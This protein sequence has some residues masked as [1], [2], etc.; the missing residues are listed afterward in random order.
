MSTQKSYRGLEINDNYGLEIIDASGGHVAVR[1]AGAEQIVAL[2][3]IDGLN[4]NRSRRRTCGSW[5][6]RSAALI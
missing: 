3:L 1:S 4:R 5:T 6:R 2:S